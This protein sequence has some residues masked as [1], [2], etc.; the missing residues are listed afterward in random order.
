MLAARLDNIFLV[1]PNPHVIEQID[2][3]FRLAPTWCTG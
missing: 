1:E 2:R 3:V